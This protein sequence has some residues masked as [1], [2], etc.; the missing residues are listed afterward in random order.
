[1][2]SR[3]LQ[4]CCHPGCPTLVKSGYCDAHKRVQPD[5]HIPEHQ[6]LYNSRR[7]KVL[8]AR[9]LASEPWCVECRKG[10]VWTAATDVDHIE[11]HRGDARKFFG[12]ELQSLC[13]TC[14]SRKTA[15]EVRG[16]GGS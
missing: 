16:R 5:R 7:W 2:P 15:E 10:G 14:H 6:R 4:P 1:M 11:P 12:G 3:P 9:Q 13:H 8:R